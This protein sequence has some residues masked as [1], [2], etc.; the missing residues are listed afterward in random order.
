MHVSSLITGS[1]MATLVAAH[2]K[3]MTAQA[4]LDGQA[5]GPVGSGI[6]FDR[7]V[8]LNGQD[9]RDVPIFKHRS[10]F[11][12]EGC[13]QNILT[14]D[15]KFQAVLE[16]QASR[17]ELTKAFAGGQIFLSFHQVNGDGN[18]P[19]H[20][21]IDA[22]GEGK[23]G[24]FKKLAI[25]KQ[26]P[27]DGPTLNAVAATNFPLIVNLPADLK[28]VGKI[29]SR[30]NI[31]LLRCQNV[32]TNGPF[33]SCVG[34]QL[35][36]KE[37]LQPLP[38]RRQKR[39]LQSRS[40]VGKR[41]SEV[42]VEPEQRQPEVGKGASEADIAKLMSNFDTSTKKVKRQATSESEKVEDTVKALTQGD[43]VPEKQLNK[44]RTEVRQR[45]RNGT[46]AHK[47]EVV[48][49]KYH[50]KKVRLRKAGNWKTKS[51]PDKKPSDK[52]KGN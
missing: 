45:I 15:I 10:M 11:L 4:L 5:V 28:C 22:K 51:S 17:G 13:G 1:L 50:E 3:V 26:V 48:G 39:R 32:A 14:G 41:A 21:G 38:T 29:G 24:S 2:G 12:W 36:P 49:K 33:G 42:P 47:V 34:I 27:G 19:F 44:L 18:G 31:C 6:G 40:R 37:D 43:D 23:K 16:G 9:L 52:K 25:A 35:V 7:G 30:E 20:C 46:L 8:P